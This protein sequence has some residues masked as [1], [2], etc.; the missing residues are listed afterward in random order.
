MPTLYD[1]LGDLSR[2]IDDDFVIV[3][4][5]GNIFQLPTGTPDRLIFNR[6]SNELTYIHDGIAIVSVY[7]NSDTIR[8]TYD[9]NDYCTRIHSIDISEEELFQL[10]LIEKNVIGI[11]EIGIVKK[12]LDYTNIKING[13]CI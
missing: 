9:F 1:I 13:E 5:T 8:Y 6:Y 4:D 12:A 7:I 10:S 11:A 3:Q 2:N